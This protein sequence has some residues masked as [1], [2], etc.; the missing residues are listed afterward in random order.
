MDPTSANE[1]VLENILKE[2]AATVDFWNEIAP[3]YDNLYKQAWSVR[4]NEFVRQSLTWLKEMRSPRILDIGCGTGLGYRLCKTVNPS[5][6]YTGIDVST[7]MI[8]QCK[9]KHPAAELIVG[10]MTQLS[11]LCDDRFD[12]VLSF[13]ASPSYAPSLNALLDEITCVIKPGGYIR[14]SVFNKTALRRLLS[15]QFRDTE[16]YGTRNAPIADDCTVTTYT[17]RRLKQQAIDRGWQYLQTDAFSVLGRLYE[18]P[19]LWQMDRAMCTVLPQL[20]HTI[21]VLFKAP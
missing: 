7:H 4:E 19:K 12:A 6:R 15:F 8:A 10:D 18:N 11:Q 21:D 1:A 20:A 13:F 17:L 9:Q 3:V 16:A 2:H 14:L 5:I